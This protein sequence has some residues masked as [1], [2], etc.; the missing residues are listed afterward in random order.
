MWPAR[1]AC[2]LVA[3]VVGGASCYSEGYDTS[4]LPEGVRADYAVFA[5]RCSR[6]HSLSRPLSAAIDDDVFWKR[7]VETMRLKP[8]SGI[9]IADEAPILRFLHYYS[10]ERRRERL[11]PGGANPIVSSGDAASGDM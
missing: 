1:T 3:L 4:R 6:C 2:G 5:D 7:Y 8:G 9:S 11:G 10:T